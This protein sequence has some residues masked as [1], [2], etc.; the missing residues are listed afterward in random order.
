MNRTRSILRILFF[1]LAIATLVHLA[2][3]TDEQAKTV[4]EFKYEMFKKV[5]TDSLDSK[6][7]LDMM[8][9]ETNRFMD[10]SSYVKNGVHKLMML[11]AIWALTEFGFVILKKRD[12]K[13]T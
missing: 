11:F 12:F 13:S 2:R 1:L 3:K 6:H 5:Q 7:K 10:S 4:V 9:R 8:L